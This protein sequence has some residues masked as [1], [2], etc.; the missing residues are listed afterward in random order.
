[1][2]QGAIYIW[3][4]LDSY[5]IIKNSLIIFAFLVKRH[6]CFG[7]FDS[8]ELQRRG[9]HVEYHFWLSSELGG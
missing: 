8:V 4:F 3:L 9:V 7:K 6:S 2:T 5:L 1:M